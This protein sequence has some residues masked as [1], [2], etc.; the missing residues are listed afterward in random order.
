MTGKTLV[1]R[2][3]DTSEYDCRTHPAEAAKS[4]NAHLA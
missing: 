2:L 4:Y 3:E 1:E